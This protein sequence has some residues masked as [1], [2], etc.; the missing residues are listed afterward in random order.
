[1]NYEDY[2][3]LHYLQESNEENER[4]IGLYKKEIKTLEED[5]LASENRYTDL[6][7]KL[8]KAESKLDEIAVIYR[9]GAFQQKMRYEHTI[10]KL[11]RKLDNIRWPYEE[12]R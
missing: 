1:M 12:H 8:K 4:A 9:A 7:L 5:L 3:D 2:R 6:E 11:L 10:E